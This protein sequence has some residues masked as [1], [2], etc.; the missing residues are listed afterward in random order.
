MLQVALNYSKRIERTREDSLMMR[1]LICSIIVLQLTNPCSLVAQDDRGQATSLFF[2]ILE[3]NYFLA[4]F[5]SFDQSKDVPPDTY[6]KQVKFR[7]AIRYRV[8][9]LSDPHYDTGIHVAYRQNSFWH[10][11]EKSAPFFDNNYNP[12]AFAYL[13]SR[14][15]AGEKAHYAPSFTAFFEHESNGQDGAN[16]RSWNRYG[17]GIDVGDYKKSPIFG[18]VRAWHAMVG[19]ENPGLPKYAGR[20][21]ISVSFQPFA[22]K[23]GEHDLGSRGFNA[24]LRFAGKPFFASQELNLFLGPRKDDM[25]E[26]GRH[27]LARLNT[28]LMLQY[29]HGTAENLLSYNDSHSAFRVG[30]ATVR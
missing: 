30:L 23:K 16:S 10:L 29:F 2:N 19:A 9:S 15:Y 13:D 22:D 17:V 14:S 6:A 27:W 28:S 21:E 5:E 3:P 8:V 26:R 11:W 1:P 20:G 4:G 7:V 12:Q 18:H 24:K 25:V